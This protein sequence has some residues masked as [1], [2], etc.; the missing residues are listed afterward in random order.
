MKRLLAR[1]FVTG[2]AAGNVLRLAPP[3]VISK[4]EMDAFV[5]ALTQELS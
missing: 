2:T 5:L 4:D 3:L 1:G